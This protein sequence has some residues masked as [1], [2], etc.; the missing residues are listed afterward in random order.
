MILF[1]V[2]NEYSFLFLY[3]NKIKMKIKEIYEK[4]LKDYPNKIKI[5]KK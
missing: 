3:I 1:F 5:F 2:R 4:L